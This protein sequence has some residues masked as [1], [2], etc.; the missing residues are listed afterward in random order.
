M[1]GEWIE[2]IRRLWTEGEFNFDGKFYK[3]PKGFGEPKPIQKPHPPIMNAGASPIGAR[4]AAKYADIAFTVFFEGAFDANKAQVDNLR[5]VAREDFHR[6]LQVWTGV[7]VVC[8]PTEK[9]AQDYANYYIYEK[10]DWEAVENLTRELGIK[11]SEYLTP[12]QL[13]R[14]K[15]RFVAGWGG[16]R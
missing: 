15:Y 16:F 5:R 8:R 1:A 4:F 9:E 10:G 6:E 14:V 7:W 2:I 12:E 11:A 13:Q 3:V